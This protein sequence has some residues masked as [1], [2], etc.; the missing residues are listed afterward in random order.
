MYT[1]A[2]S[3]SSGASA[4]AKIGT[5]SGVMSASPHQLIA[6]GNRFNRIT[7]TNQTIVWAYL[8]RYRAPKHRPKSKER[9][10]HMTSTVATPSRPRCCR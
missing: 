5:E 4:Y 2:H 1:S 10:W 7:L 3:Y 6:M 9:P 8:G